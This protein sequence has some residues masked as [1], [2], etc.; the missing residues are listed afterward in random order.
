MSFNISNIEN[1]NLIEVKLSINFNSLIFIPSFPNPY[2][3][4]LR[5]CSF[6]V[7]N[8]V[9]KKLRIVYKSKL[10]IENK[11]AILFFTLL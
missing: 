9:N 5:P 4:N 6:G 1:M 8:E 2:L 3:I 7:S 11:I 10:F